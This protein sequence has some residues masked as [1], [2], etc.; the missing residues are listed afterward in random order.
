[1]RVLL[2]YFA[3]INLIILN[4]NSCKPNRNENP[5]EIEFWHFQSEPNQKKVLLKIISEFESKYNCK[6][7]LTDLSWKDG[8]TKL[9]AAFHSKTEPDVIELGSDWVAQ[10]SSAGVLAE[11][12]NKHVEFDKFIE[13]STEP[14]MY[15]YKIFALP[16]YVDTRVLFYNKTLL[17]GANINIDSIITFDDLINASKKIQL[18]YKNE[19]KYGIAVNG[20]DAHRLY[21]KVV[22]Y[23]WSYGG[24]ILDK[25][26]NFI[27]NSKN[28]I[29]AIEK[30]KVSK[31]YGLMENQRTLDG[32]FIQG[33][34]GFI[35]SGAWIIEKIKNENPN[36]K[37]GVRTLPKTESNNGISFAG[38]EYLAVT[39][40]GGRKPLAKE[41]VKFLSDG[42]NAIKFCK[43]VPEAGFPADKNYFNDN[44]YKTQ[45]IRSVFAEQLKFAKMTPVHKYWL[46]IEEHL[47]KAVEEVLYDKKSSEQAL[48]DLQKVVT[49][50]YS[51]K[52]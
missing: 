14:S 3:L 45:A 24:D 22:T 1:M 36:L 31:S 50:K 12:N 13:F 40:Q 10:F 15:N 5:K 29:K 11:L 18:Q 39:K 9:F 33:N 23:L 4:L 46:E 16:W 51:K 44:Y 48:N 28:N 20:P 6:I 35:I 38:G 47:E 21:K 17:E 41:F 27:L 43:E 7:K 49:E 26:G 30:Y 52:N 8:K 25:N 32:E 34:I 42:K 2:I 37:Y 19:N